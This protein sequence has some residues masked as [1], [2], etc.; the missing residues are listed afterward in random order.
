MTSQVQL[1]TCAIHVA[2]RIE[3]GFHHQ[4]KLHLGSS[5][6]ETVAC[7][8]PCSVSI[9]RVHPC[10]PARLPVPA[11]GCRIEEV[12]SERADR[13]REGSSG[14]VPFPPGLTWR[15]SAYITCK[16]GH[17]LSAEYKSS[18]Y[19][20]PCLQPAEGIPVRNC[21]SIIVSKPCLEQ[22]A[23]RASRQAALKCIQLPVKQKLMWGTDT[24]EGLAMQPVPFPL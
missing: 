15:F 4:E 19:P 9:P 24:P 16:Q 5:A 2:Q 21:S 17:A 20:L 10:P 1:R 8:A 12:E 7:K 22:D 3:Q 14:G 23:P 6:R 13:L 11:L 18:C